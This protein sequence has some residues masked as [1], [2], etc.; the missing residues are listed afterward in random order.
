[1]TL[2]VLGV[3]AAGASTAAAAP[4]WGGPFRLA[5]PVPL[6]VVPG[7][8]AFSPTGATAVGYS[9]EDMDNPADSSARVLHR[10]G[11]ARFGG[12]HKVAGQ[13]QILDLAY[14]S[15][16][17]ELLAGTS[18]A[19]RSCC[20]QVQALGPVH[21]GSFG[22]ARTLVSALAGATQ[23][24]LINLPNRLLA[25]VGTERGVWVSQSAAGG[26]RFAA[27]RRLSAANQLPQSVE[28][29]A[30]GTGQS[31]VAWAARKDQVTADGPRSI[32]ISSGSAQQAPVRQHLALTVP[33][34]H[35][36][37]EIGLAQGANLPTLAWIES[38]FDRNGNFHSQAKVADLSA[39]LRPQAVSSSSELAS[40]LAFASDGR[41]DQALT[42][43]ACTTNGDCATRVVLR[44]AS[45]RFGSVQRPGAIDA[46]DT[47][48]AAVTLGARALI[49]WVHSGHVLAASSQTTRLSR[50]SVVSNT[51]FAADLSLTATPTGGAL[52]VW[53]QGTLAQSVM[54]ADFRRR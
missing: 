40:G 38:W 37:D 16:G 52:A 48:V 8:T 7:Q 42:W 6:D 43:K 27:A 18:E 1:V 41:G 19:G 34:N 46:S 24:R 35:Q 51:G 33:A 44:R 47:P 26:D 36:V 17:L 14:G 49:G 28:A 11:G 9:V 30:L 23:A 12:S 53:T 20:S 22:Q 10:R 32:Y 2:A 21:G 45:G 25:V 31:L 4:G 50:A 13:Q 54:G 5:A 29:I 3:L 15:K 39:R